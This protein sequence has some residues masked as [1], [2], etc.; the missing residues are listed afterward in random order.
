MIFF[1]LHTMK[2]KDSTKERKIM[3]VTIDIVAE[4]GIA[5]VKMS[6][7]AKRVKVSSSNLYIY[8]KNKEDLLLSVFFDT[9]K[10]LVKQFDDNLPNHSIYKKRIFGLFQHMVKIKVNKIK[11]FSFVYQ[12]IQSPYFK[13]EYFKKTD[14]ILKNIFDIFREGQ[15]DL[16]LKDD[17][18]IDLILA[19]V[20]GTTSKLVELHNKGKIKLNKK[21]MDKS[22][23]M[24]WD[25][26][27]Q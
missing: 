2:L 5:G 14:L 18:E 6:E 1:Y 7:V 3:N 12:F 4:N 26:I 25:A 22:F 19:L 10:N 11:E 23:G 8:F 9:A 24:I 21:T 17:V 13:G 20:D 27:R 15:K 16:I